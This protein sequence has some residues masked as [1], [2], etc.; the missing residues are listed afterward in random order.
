MTSRPRAFPGDMP[1]FPFEAVLDEL[2]F[3]YGQMTDDSNPCKQSLALD[4]QPAGPGHV[5]RRFANVMGAVLSDG[6]FGSK[7]VFI[8][9]DKGKTS[10]TVVHY[11]ADGHLLWQLP[12][13]TVTPL[14]CGL[15]GQV[16]SWACRSSPISANVWA[17]RTPRPISRASRS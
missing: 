13:A 1:E 3:E 11:D 2:I 10:G 14:R 17:C 7:T 4:E 9:E 16:L 8:D 6:S 12:A 5:M 15:M